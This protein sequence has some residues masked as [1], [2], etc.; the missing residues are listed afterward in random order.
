MHAEAAGAAE[1]FTAPSLAS[2][3]LLRSPPATPRGA[4]TRAALVAAARTVFERS[5]YLDA[6]LSDIT[7]LANC[8]S[9]TF[10][11]YFDGKEQ[12][13]AAVMEAAQEEMLH[14]GMG[15]VGGGDD[16]RAVLE[17][18]NRA[19]LEAY[20]RN[21]ELMRL[22]E[23]VAHVDPAFRELRQAR[24]EAF[25]RR[26][27]RGIAELQKRGVAD[28]DIDP[29]LASRALSGMVSRLAYSFFVDGD[30]VQEDGAPPDFDGLVAAVTRLWAA[31]LCFR[32]V[33][34]HG[35]PDRREP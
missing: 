24:A 28:T 15:R 29:V 3:E 33:P 8:S 4:R 20:G 10:Y 13:F 17:A 26:N 35:G 7:K 14:P 2:A 32:A 22:L 25:I 16:P 34:E 1:D 6:R 27:A 18:G 23:Q 30:C 12:I 21:A 5:G 31:A 9:G 19:Y 11:T